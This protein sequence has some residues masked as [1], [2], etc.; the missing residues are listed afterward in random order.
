MSMVIYNYV[1][2]LI[3]KSIE[4]DMNWGDWENEWPKSIS[5]EGDEWRIKNP[6][7]SV[8]SLFAYVF[9]WIDIESV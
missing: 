1:D 5:N 2:S 6:N 8:Q 7:V 9:M 4:M 3:L